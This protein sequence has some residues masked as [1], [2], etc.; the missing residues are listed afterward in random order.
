MSYYYYGGR[1]FFPCELDPTFWS[2]MAVQLVGEVPEGLFR[3]NVALDKLH[4]LKVQIMRGGITM[5]VGNNGL[6]MFNQLGVGGVVEA[7]ALEAQ[8]AEDQLAG[9]PLLDGSFGQGSLEY[10][11]HD[12]V[13]V[14]PGDAGSHQRVLNGLHDGGC[15]QVPSLGGVDASRPDHIGPL[16]G[17]GFEGSNFVMHGTIGAGPDA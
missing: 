10:G 7:E 12:V 15:H 1:Q 4:V 3:P 8:G 2:K 5:A 17:L 6:Q 14:L 9:E 16:L 13:H 11:S